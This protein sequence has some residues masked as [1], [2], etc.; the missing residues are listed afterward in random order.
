MIRSDLR[1]LHLV[2]EVVDTGNGIV[3]VTVD[4][5]I[6]AHARGHEVAVASSGGGFVDLLRSSGVAHHRIDFRGEPLRSFSKLR[7]LIADFQPDIV[8]AHT[9]APCVLAAAVR[10]VPGG[11]DFTLVATMH[12]VYQRSSL[13]MASADMTVGVAQSV[14]DVVGSRRIRSPLLATVVNGVVNSPRRGRTDP[15]ARGLGPRSIVAVG[16]V[17]HRKGVDVLLAAFEILATTRRDLHLWFIGNKDWE[18]FVHEAESSVHADRVHLIGLAD[19]PTAFLGEATVVALASRREGLALSL[20]EA[21]EAGAAIVA[22]ETDGAR[23]GL[24][25]GEAGLLV[26]V[27]DP[28]ALATALARVI[29]DRECRDDLRRRSA[30]GLDRFSVTRMAREYEEVYRRAITH[31]HT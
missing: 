7:A 23:E 4:L 25:A 28:D 22:T 6:D 3:N 19:D 12:N 18:E 8:H 24:D 30:N 2:N 21:R 17:S 26:P 20:L 29:D 15:V 14:S 31:R 16:A 5:A 13:L 27:D 10:A 1:V 9:V 11:P